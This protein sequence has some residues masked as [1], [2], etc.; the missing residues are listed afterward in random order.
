[1]SASTQYFD[2]L[3]SY[4]LVFTLIDTETGTKIPLSSLGTLR[5]TQFYYNPE[6]LT[7]DAKHLATINSRYKQNIKNANDVVVSTS[8]TVTW[9]VQPSDNTKLD[10]DTEQEL[11]IALF[12]WTYGNGKRNS[13]AFFDYVRKVPYMTDIL[14]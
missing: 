8:G 3:N 13:H 12:V 14:T 4:K 2:E 6:L 7:A 9:Q 11:H 10:T 5:C 1:M